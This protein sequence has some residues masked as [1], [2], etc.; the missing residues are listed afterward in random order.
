[1]TPEYHAHYDCHWCGDRKFRADIIFIDDIPIC[2]KGDCAH[3]YRQSKLPGIVPRTRGF[4]D[5][6]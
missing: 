3:E 2:L 6:G 5:K 4:Y 1:M